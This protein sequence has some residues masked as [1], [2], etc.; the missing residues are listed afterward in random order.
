MGASQL[1]RFSRSAG[2]TVWVPTV[3]KAGVMTMADLVEEVQRRL[4]TS[5]PRMVAW[6]RAQNG[7]SMVRDRIEQGDLEGALG[8]LTDAASWF[9]TEVNA[10]QK[11]AAFNASRDLERHVDTLLTFDESNERAVHALRQSRIEDIAEVSQGARDTVRS[12]ISDGLTRGAN[13]LE[14]ARDVKWTIGL[15]DAQAQYVLNF[16]AELQRGDWAAARSRALADGRWDR[17][18]DRLADG[19]GPP[20]T[21]AQ[22]DAMVNRYSDNWVAFRAETIARTEGLRAA[23]VGQHMMY[24]Q[25]IESGKV[26]GEDLTRQWLHGPRRKHSRDGHVAMHKQTRPWGEAFLN[27]VTGKTLMHPGDP[28]APLSETANCTCAETIRYVA[29]RGATRS[30]VPSDI[31]EPD[32]TE[33]PPPAVATPD[34]LQSFRPVHPADAPTF[35]DSVADRPLTDDQQR[36]LARYQGGAFV[37]VN[38]YAR[39]GRLDAGSSIKTKAEAR[40]VVADLDDAVDSGSLPTD[41]MLFRG[42]KQGTREGITGRLEVGSVIS[43]K[44]F[45]STSLSRSTAEEFGSVL[46]EIEAPEGTRAVYIPADGSLAESEILLGR[47]THMEV[48]DVRR[49]GGRVVAR[50]RVVS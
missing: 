25:A 45:A 41:T 46:L 43:D 42:I 32:V 36:A 28:E 17:T 35:V 18:F 16:R 1:V 44:T 23:H 19:R 5:W 30:F 2:E 38:D 10:A 13:P 27:P 50:V 12:V 40:D 47:D 3:A 34:P 11:Y 24:E 37:D 15:T 7:L 39:T 48:I 4:G 6:L 33:T 21:Q 26:D 49:D 8:G 14:V 31:E 20:L 29:T 22:Q 9:A